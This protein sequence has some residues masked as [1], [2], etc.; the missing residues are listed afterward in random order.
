MARSRSGTSGSSASAVPP[1]LFS[2]QH[3]VD[4]FEALLF[5]F[6]FLVA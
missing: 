2:A 3:P 1:D 4:G 6:D 5:G